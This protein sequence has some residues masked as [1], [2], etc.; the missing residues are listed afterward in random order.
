MPNE[1]SPCKLF[2]PLYFLVLSVWPI[3]G[4]L[5]GTDLECPS[6]KLTSQAVS[7]ILEEIL[8]FLQRGSELNVL[9]SVDKVLNMIKTFFLVVFRILNNLNCHLVAEL[10]F[11]FVLLHSNNIH[12]FG[13]FFK[14]YL[15]T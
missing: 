9:L 14:L 10:W 11:R 12:L 6:L 4:L 13:F 15:G 1:I 2:L 8:Y 7:M 5:G 3:A